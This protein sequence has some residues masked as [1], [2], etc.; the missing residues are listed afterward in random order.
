MLFLYKHNVIT[1]EEL[2]LEQRKQCDEVMDLFSKTLASAV[3]GTFNETLR[4]CL[5]S[6][7][8]ELIIVADAFNLFKIKLSTFEDYR[9]LMRRLNET[10]ENGEIA[11]KVV[12]PNF[13]SDFDNCRVTLKVYYKPSDEPLVFP[14]ELV[15]EQTEAAESIAQLSNRSPDEVLESFKEIRQMIS[16]DTLDQETILEIIRKLV[17]SEW[18]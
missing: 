15:E 1:N 7:G 18:D 2:S 11:T 14:D 5:D 9:T 3:G 13:Y 4:P 8:R 6:R 10:S 12:Y 16:T 17:R